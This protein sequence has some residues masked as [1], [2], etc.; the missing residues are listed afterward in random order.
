MDVV[1]ILLDGGAT[2]STEALARTCRC[3]HVETLQLL[4]ERGADANADK[5][6]YGI[7]VLLV[8]LLAITYVD[9]GWYGYVGRCAIC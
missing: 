8:Q 3:G 1:R 2:I 5:V 4:L 9:C 7:D 6:C